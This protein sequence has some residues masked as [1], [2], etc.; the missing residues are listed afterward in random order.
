MGK[1]LIPKKEAIFL[2]AAI[3]PLTTLEFIAKN[4]GGITWEQ[5]VFFLADEQGIVGTEPSLFKSAFLLIFVKPLLIV[6][7]TFFVTGK[8][9]RW[10]N[11]QLDDPRV[12]HMTARRAIFSTM[13]LGKWA[14]KRTWALSIAAFIYLLLEIGAASAF[15]RA[16][17]DDLFARVYVPP[18]P[19][20]GTVARPE[21][22]LVLLYVES[23][24]SSLRDTNVFGENLLAPIDAAFRQEPFRLHQSP[25][26]GWTTAGMVSSQCAVPLLN[27]MGNRL[28]H[29]SGKIMASA[30]CVGDYLA[31]MG[32]RQYFYVGP[33]LKFSGMDKFYGGHG[34][35]HLIGLEQL[36]TLGLD[37][38]LFTGWGDGLHDDMLLETAFQQ[39]EKLHHEKV[40]FNVSIIT[41]DNH[42]PD[43]FPSERCHPEEV[44]GV[45]PSTFKCT[46]RQIG[47]FLGKL[48]EAKILEDTVVVVMGDH[49]FFN[50]ETHN[51]Y[52]SKVEQRFVYFNF[53]DK[54]SPSKPAARK[55]LTHFDVAPSI[56]EMMTGHTGYYS[57]MG[58]GISI[59]EPDSEQYERHLSAV[60]NGAILN[61]S[62]TYKALW[63]T[64]EKRQQP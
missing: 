49:L 28:S 39:I 31:Q 15:T 44:A 30:T 24:E 8:I 40:P 50:N 42:A 59:F 43:G 37:K 23:L 12:Q 17:G 63:K 22:N 7:V 13:N 64:P 53:I 34:Y 16:Y 36:Q 3:A 25:G 52:F 54:A 45:F 41:T 11:S 4:F 60:T 55:R 1:F 58:L 21:K 51:K 5:I 20:T 48:N 62:E 2:Y 33:D 10:L 14:A 46:S 18:P 27:F 19:L 47:R 38:S 9:H 35:E 26:T 32:Y 61:H 6:A 29:K 57:R 56:M